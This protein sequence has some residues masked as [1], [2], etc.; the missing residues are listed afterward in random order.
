MENSFL[1]AGL[2][3]PGAQ[4][5]GTRHNIGF[6]VV[7][8]LA[9][10]WSAS[11]TFQPG[12]KAR[13]ARASFN[14]KRVLLCQP[15]TYMNLSGEAVGAVRH[16]YKTALAQ[17]LVVMDDA[18]LPLGTI[19]LRPSGSSGG[20]HGLES[21]EQH[22]GSRG[23]LRQRI[24]I[25]RQHAAAREITSHVLGRFLKDELPLVNRVLEQAVAQ[26]ECWLSQGLEKA[27]N[28]FNGAVDA[29]NKG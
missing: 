11:W 28:Q 3:N 16:F 26:L 5:E 17:T 18:N 1:I 10:R 4:Y 7:D 14:G 21:I 6:A 8:C 29:P 15:Q 20:H 25:G 9:Q 22:L 23:Y 24:G 27:M 12:C 19:R 13:L 2:G